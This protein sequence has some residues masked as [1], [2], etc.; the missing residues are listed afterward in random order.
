MHTEPSFGGTGYSYF[1]QHCSYQSTFASLWRKYFRLLRTLSS[2]RSC[3]W[4]A[5]A[6]AVQCWNIFSVCWWVVLTSLKPPLNI[7]LSDRLSHNLDGGW[8]R[9]VIKRRWRWALSPPPAFPFHPCPVILS[10]V[11]NINWFLILGFSGS[12]HAFPFPFRRLGFCV[13]F[14]CQ[15]QSLIDTPELYRCFRVV[16]K[17]ACVRLLFLD[18]LCE[19]IMVMMV[20]SEALFNPALPIRRRKNL[21]I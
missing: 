7:F 13:L 18:S 8:R 11:G 16:Q 12:P 19:T 3:I 17:S 5:A 4:S 1:N 9:R 6:H 20:V 14:G 15:W 21:N 2:W 10:F